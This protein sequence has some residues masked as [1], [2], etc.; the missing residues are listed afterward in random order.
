MKKLSTARKF[1]NKPRRGDIVRI[2]VGSKYRSS[3]KQSLID[4]ETDER[5]KCRRSVRNEPENIYAIWLSR[6]KALWII[7]D[8]YLG[9]ASV[10]QRVTLEQ[11]ELIE[12]RVAIGPCGLG[13]LL[14]TRRGDHIATG[15]AR[16]DVASR[17][18][19]ETKCFSR[20]GKR[21]EMTALLNRPAARVR[22]GNFT[23]EYE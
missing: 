9:N 23:N 8:G 13:L 4:A 15:Q 3:I 19:A 1:S 7:S 14:S 2:Y 21:E 5:V 22:P 18:T 16:S 10:V 6:P 11:Q 17:E 12:R 20:D